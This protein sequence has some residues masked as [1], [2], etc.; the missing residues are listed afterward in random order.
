MVS[1]S[2]IESALNAYVND[3]SLGGAATLAWRDG[4]I[5]HTALV[6]RR[7]LAT[8]LPVERDTIFR[9]ASM[10]KPVTA[11]AALILYDEGRFALDEPI[12]RH[13]P[14]LAR[15]RVLR[16]PNGPLDQT[17]EAEQPITFGDL[18]THR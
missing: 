2:P 7:D 5:V 12:T 18:L 8:N 13:A 9:I 14:E 1:E 10:T 11:V 15:L 6:G 16:D 3:G 17:E 4:R